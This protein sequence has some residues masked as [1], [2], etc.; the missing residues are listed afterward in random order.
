MSWKLSHKDLRPLQRNVCESIRHRWR[1]WQHPGAVS[2]ARPILHFGPVGFARPGVVVLGS[3][4]RFRKC[5]HKVLSSGAKLSHSDPLP[6]HLS[7]HDMS[8]PR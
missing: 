8:L 1:T 4:V 6:E 7:R 2:P 5:T 3:D